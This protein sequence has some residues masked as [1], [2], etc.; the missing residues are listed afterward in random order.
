MMTGVTHF[1]I[2]INIITIFFRVLNPEH[3][4]TVWALKHGR[5]YSYDINDYIEMCDSCHHLYDMTPEVRVRLLNGS[6]TQRR[7]VMVRVNGDIIKFE[8]ISE[9]GRKLKIGQAN[10][11]MCLCGKSRTAG[12]YNWS[13]YLSKKPLSG[14]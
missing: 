5:K 1:N 13:Y 9:A 14:P 10:I 7:P 8:S 4:R 6:I 11:S 12:G 2:V 3:K